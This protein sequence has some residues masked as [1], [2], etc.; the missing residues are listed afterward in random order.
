MDMAEA[1]AEAVKALGASRI[2]LLTPYVEEVAKHNAA[3]LREMVG[4]EVVSQHNMGLVTDVQITGVEPEE[5]RRLALSI[6]CKTAQIVVLGC[7]AFRAC[8][9][10][11]IS[12]LERQL[13]KPVVTS[14]QAYLWWL[15]RT[16]G[17]KDQVEGYGRL[18]SHC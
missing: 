1:Q 13:G 9:P 3:M 14:T 10:G 16:A 17:I 18:F 2:A 15:L 7:S 5:I 6:N 4:V 8:Q 11:F 12:D